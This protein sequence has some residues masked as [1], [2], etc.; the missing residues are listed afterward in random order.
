VFRRIGVFAGGFTLELAQDVASDER[1][2][3]WLVLELLGHLID[4]SLVIA[5]GMAEPR[6]SLLETTR[7]YALEQLA[8]S[9]ESA[10]L[11]RRHAAALRDTMRALDRRCWNLTP[12]DRRVTAEE[13]GNLRAALDWAG[14]DGAEWE[15]HHELLATCW[16][17]WLHNGLVGEG[18]RRMLELWPP[19]SDLSPR[20]EADF[21][22]ALARLNGGCGRDHHLEAARRAA[23][24]L[25]ELHDDERLGD[26]LLLCATIGASSHRVAEAERALDEAQILVSASAAPRRRAALA[27]TQGEIAI[28]R[29]N[30]EQ[31]VAAFRR[32]REFYVQ[33]GA[34][35]GEYLALGNIGGALLQTG[36]TTAAIELLQ[37]SIDG[38]E[39][40]GAPYGREH[41]LSRLILARALRGDDIDVPA[42]ARV[43]YYEL[44]PLGATFALL[45]AAALHRLRLGEFECAVRLAAHV[46]GAPAGGAEQP[47]PFDAGLLQRI[48]DVAR[49]R[50]PAPTVERWIR[51]G[52][53]VTPA[54]A[55]DLAFGAHRAAA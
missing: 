39:R 43:A 48:F 42:I 44:R 40:L 54:E 49:A 8:A 51:A 15:L 34:A 38:L 10:A 17:F 37:R 53:L 19:R 28:Q 52:E 13:L 3:P 46:S 16:L 2:D 25:R 4:K 27:A 33:A 41:R 9:G 7:A 45:I 11:L 6:Y 26:A 36:D 31:A 22:L 29:G 20:L 35:L 14:A 30:P 55:A 21:C 5:D 23:A 1:L 47:C 12:G 32:Q 24:R 50:H 18:T